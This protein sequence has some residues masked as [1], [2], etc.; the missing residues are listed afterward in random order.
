MLFMLSI[1][2]LLHTSLEKCVF[3]VQEIIITENGYPAESHTV[4]TDD[5]YILEMH[6]IPFGKNSPLVAGEVRWASIFFFS[7]LCNLYSLFFFMFF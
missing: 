7:W 5:C 4:E 2:H 6:R 3:L 1:L